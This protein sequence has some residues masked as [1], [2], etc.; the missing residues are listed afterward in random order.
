[1]TSKQRILAALR[2]QEVDR[3]P[4]APWFFM[5]RY[6]GAEPWPSSR[7]RLEFVT[8]R[9]GLDAC[10][11]AY[12]PGSMTPGV[13]AEFHTSDDGQV[14]HK[15]FHT[16]DGDL[17]AAIR[18]HEKLPVTDDIELFSDF[19]GP[20]YVKP[21]IETARDVECFRH[22]YAPP[23][24][25]TLAAC[26]PGFEAA[27]ALADEF[28]LPVVTPVGHGLTGL[29]SMM[30]GEA[31]VLASMDDPAMVDR[32]MQID[33]EVNLAGI[34][35]VM[36]LGADVIERNGF[37]ETC[38]FWSPR[39]VEQLVMGRLDAEARRTHAAGGLM[40]YTACTGI[41]PLLDL[42]LDS[43]IDCIQKYETQLTGQYL[44][45][46][47]AKLAGRK[48]LWGGISDCEDLGRSTPAQTREAVRDL[49]DTVGRRGLIVAASPSIKPERPVANV[50]AMFDEWRKLR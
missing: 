2:C 9:L 18:L 11:G 40:V 37:Y 31:A 47:A 23:T 20:L 27:K 34:D 3:V 33:H 1:M 6:P 4:C 17:A 41:V 5:G 29:V 43:E 24:D 10:A 28:A 39:Q 35:A 7:A 26:R 13:E 49:F 19:N 50:E 45:P 48:A 32:Y 36:D 46:I 42:Y 16:P 38:E 15:V 14:L 30:G 12:L 21:W 8:G 25:E 22:V 44:G